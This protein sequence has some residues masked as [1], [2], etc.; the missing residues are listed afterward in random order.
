MYGHIAE[1]HFVGCL[2]GNWMWKV[3]ATFFCINLLIK[4]KLFGKLNIKL[5][6]VN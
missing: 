1:Q 2:D 5:R 4:V 6:I 3:E